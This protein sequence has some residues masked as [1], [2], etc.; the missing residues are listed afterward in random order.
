MIRRVP[1]DRPMS[2]AYRLPIRATSVSSGLGC[3]RR[4]GD[5]ACEPRDFCDNSLSTFDGEE[6]VEMATIAAPVEFVETLASL[7]FP[8]KSDALLQD[9]MDRNTEGKLSAGERKELEALVE[10]SERLSIL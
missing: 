10:L 3:P 2:S 4:G 7:R 5:S 1:G 6:G 8:E 9:L